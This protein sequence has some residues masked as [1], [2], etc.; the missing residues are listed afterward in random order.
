MRD[1]KERQK[2]NIEP[3]LRHGGVALLRHEDGRRKGREGRTKH[4]VFQVRR[5]TALEKPNGVPLVRI[6]V[7]GAAIWRQ[8]AWKLHQ[9]CIKT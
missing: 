2:K 7:L 4:L 8:P 1:D 5:V 3:R 6:G 9:G